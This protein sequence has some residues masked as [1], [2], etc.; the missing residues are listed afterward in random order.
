MHATAR[1]IALA[2]SL[3]LARSSLLA[4]RLGAQQAQQ[5][6]QPQPRTDIVRGRVIGADTMPI[7]NAQVTA[8]DTAAKVPKQMR[9]DAKG[10]FAFTF[11]NGGG[12][13]MVAVTMLGYAPQRRVVTRG[14]DGKIPDLQFKMSQVAAQLGAVRS[15]G[16]RPRPPR[17]EAQGDAGVGGTQTFTSLS[18]GLT[19]DVTGDL[20]AA[21]ATIPGITITPSA[22][23]GL[24]S[25]SAFGI[26]GEQNSITLN[27]LG[28]GGNVPRDGFSMSVVSASY[29][30]SK[31]GF[32]GVQQ[33]LRMQSG[34][35]FITRSIHATLDAPTLQWT[36]PV[37]STLNTRYDQ[38]IL[39][40]TL[41]G[42]IVTDHVFYATSYQ[43]QRRTSGL[44]SLATAD[45]ASLEALRISPDS[46]SKL[47]IALGPNGIP[48]RT[49]GVPSQRENMETRLATRIDWIPHPQP[50]PSGV[51]F[52]GPPSVTQDA[53]YVEA[54]G[55]V[56]NNDG[57]MIGA[58][59]V[60]SFGGA[61]THR[62]GWA[63]FTAA[64]YLPKS[65]LN[66]TSVSV[67][68]GVDRTDPYLA[69]P[70]ANILVTSNLDDG[71]LGLSSLQV[72]G[73]SQP[74]SSSRNWLTEVRNQTSFTTWN[75]KHSAALSLSASED[76]Y[77]FTQDATNGAFTFNSLAD[78]ENG[79]PASFSRTLTDQRRSGNGMAAA[80]GIGDVYTP[81]QPD[82]QRGQTGPVMQYGVRF[83]A[84]RIGVH[85]AFN[86]EVD[87]VF[88]LRTDHVP[89]T[90]GILPMLG[91]RW[92]VFGNY[93]TSSGINFGTRGQLSGG[94]RKYRGAF[95]ARSIDS[96]ARQ[97][98]L[99][100]A[101]QQLFCVGSAAPAPTWQNYDASTGA[102]P[103]ACADGSI[104]SALAQT[105]PP[106]AVL[107]PNYQLFE[108]W[109]PALNLLYRA[110]D[111]LQ[112]TINGTFASN[113]NMASPVDVNFNGVQR[114]TLPLEGNRPVYVS[115][116]SVVPTTGAAAWTDSRVSPL[117]A[118]V[119]ETRSDLRSESFTLGGTL[120]YFP[121][122]FNIT[123][124]SFNAQLGYSYSDSREQFRG[125]TGGTD[126]DPREVGWSRGIQARH[127]VTMQFT[128]RRDR[129]GYVQL[130]GRMQ[131]GAAYTP[132]VAGDINGDGY[133]NDRAFIF[134]PS[135]TADTSIG[136]AMSRLLSS[137]PSGA[138][139]CLERQLG[140]V[141]GRASCVAPWAFT[142][143]SVSINPD[144]YRLGLGNRG[145]VSILVNNILSGV[146][147]ALHGS[148]NLHGWGQAAIA[149]SQLLTV[150]GF[151][152]ATQ[153]FL[154]TVNP[155]FGSTSVFRNTFRQP[156]QITLDF[157]MDV[158][159]DRESQYLESLLRPRKADGVSVLSE[160][161]IKQKIARAYNPIDALINVKDSLKLTDSQ[162]DMMRKG[163][164]R[165][166]ASRDSVV[167][168]IA[169]YLAS[170]N[171]DYSGEDVRQRW[172]EAGL[173]TYA[174]FLNG[175]RSIL[176]LLTP[177]QVARANKLPQTAGLISQINSIK[178]GDLANM[179]RS[180]LSSLP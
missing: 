20:T 150:R 122:S 118:H 124:W 134:N 25:V 142:N 64:K 34:S 62:D 171:G 117:F 32:A 100:D 104:G 36:T 155:Q 105:T 10:A 151:D 148:N 146:D 46:V 154:Y 65:V 106:V 59:S 31:G 1:A 145:S 121:I 26:P 125:F 43:L 13:Y 72:G 180:P 164:A 66:E 4:P 37:A 91:F 119:A 115:P 71:Q 5:P 131:S 57:A 40:G 177:E 21:L 42:P 109:R 45:A 33:S 16:E 27:G 175:Y 88:G 39:S 89:T 58:T 2:A 128:A 19:G 107:A 133:S 38:Q 158:S 179:F 159:P 52:F 3:V 7:A 162:I 127:S 67:S 132:T 77:S 120:G 108:S 92:P 136:N 63:Q 160:Q 55:S 85:P 75:R 135:A 48:V 53:Y 70:T 129:L 78:F 176:A 172:H 14:A 28:F 97:T 86:R 137:A 101:V 98:G 110:T 126:G 23:G 123:S 56:R 94:I 140:T 54:G 8:V 24:A 112:T 138:R 165:Y 163:S 103:G 147:Q 61:Q 30:P 167:T 81:K 166:M 114:F 156:F 84:N 170:R 113:R 68:G 141:A 80:I 178:E 102:I 60:P 152:P 90:T 168:R 18:N 99:P 95:S 111:W 6:Q 87:S 83:E 74:R 15:V 169:K 174:A 173:Q 29:D 47:F 12:S 11:D 49:P 139:A 9:T 41:A 143:L 73:S 79:V 93:T 50:A 35:N 22:T 96:Y 44:T 116:L 149:Q 76:G 51:F 153:R 157:R 144:S 82:P 130:F 17:S 69:L 161:Q